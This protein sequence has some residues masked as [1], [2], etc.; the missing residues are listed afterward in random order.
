MC[1]SGDDSDFLDGSSTIPSIEERCRTLSLIEET[2]SKI[3]SVP[4]GH[5]SFDYYER[6]SQV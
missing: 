6:T 1:D 3:K 2:K 4:P 5:P